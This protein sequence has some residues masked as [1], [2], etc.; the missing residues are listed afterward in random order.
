MIILMLKHFQYVWLR[1]REDQKGDQCLQSH[2]AVSTP[3]LFHEAQGFVAVNILKAALSMPY[4][5]TIETS[6]LSSSMSLSFF[7][8]PFFLLVPCSDVAVGSY[9]SLPA[10]KKRQYH[11]KH[12]TVNSYSSRHELHTQDCQTDKI[13]TVY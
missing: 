9:L 12:L 6:F 3:A 5:L 10:C 8:F 7:F 2:H 4:T 1:D 13:I 11:K